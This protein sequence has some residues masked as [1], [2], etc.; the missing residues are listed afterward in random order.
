MR[1]F[2]EGGR[3][4]GDF[5]VGRTDPSLE[6]PVKCFPQTKR[7]IAESGKEKVATWG[8]R[9]DGTSGITTRKRSWSERGNVP[10]NDQIAV[11]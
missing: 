7:S 6:G 1:V 11:A 5:E 9:K 8:P 3:E 4:K 2:V 10:N